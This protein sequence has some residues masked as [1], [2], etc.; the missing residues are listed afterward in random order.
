M[1]INEHYII[2]QVSNPVP[3]VSH[4]D[5]LRKRMLEKNDVCKQQKITELFKKAPPKPVQLVCSSPVYMLYICLPNQSNR[6]VLFQFTCC[7]YASQT[8][9]TG[10]F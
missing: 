9:P 5:W 10:L 1:E 2:L 8:S 7:T 3:R 4:P 6:S